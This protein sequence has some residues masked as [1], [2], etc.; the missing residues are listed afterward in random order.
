[1]AGA[2]MLTKVQ[3]VE[4]AQYNIYVNAIAPGW[5]NTP[6]SSSFFKDK[7]FEKKI[8]SRVPL[9]RLGEPSEIAPLAVF[10]ASE[11]S[12]FMTGEIIYIDGGMTALSSGALIL[13]G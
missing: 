8:V 4:W 3:A 2:I 5:L 11:A 9:K 1:M 10:L 6:D 13:E 12:N 7:D